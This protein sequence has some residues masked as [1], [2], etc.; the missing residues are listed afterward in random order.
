[1][2]KTIRTGVALAVA[3]ALILPLG[4]NA[5]ASEPTREVDP[6]VA[7]AA[8]A[9]KYM[10]APARINQTVP[11]RVPAPRGV[12]VTVLNPGIPAF[13]LQVNGMEAA[14]KE[15]GW[16]L[17]TVTYDPASPA[18]LNTAMLKAL[19]TDPDVTIN[20][21]APSTYSA[22]TV[23]EY[24]NAGVPIVGASICPFSYK[25]PIFQ[26]A[27]GCAN[28]DVAGRALANWFIA[29]SRGQGRA[30]FGSLTAI[31]TL[32]AFA[33]AFR[34]EVAK[35]CPKCSVE[36]QDTTLQAIGT[37]QFI[38]SLVNRLRQ[39]P[40]LKYLFFDNAS[41]ATGINAALDAAGL[42]Y[43]KV[44]GRA[45]D[46]AAVSALQQGK[47]A[48]WIAFPYYVAGY[49]NIDAALRLI[50]KSSGIRKNEVSPF[51]ILT[52]K[53]SGRVTLPY[54]APANALQQYMRIWRR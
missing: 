4:S 36:T 8:I 15:L 43:V 23:S 22:S 3:G 54:N 47:Q 6:V 35:K 42:G 1:M 10:R 16:T 53:N 28:E 52:P 34:D 44:G 33:T 46:A 14:A 30:L 29:D 27:N 40:S 7:A 17:T 20:P 31:P 48:A 18:S 26:G 11:L 32:V 45:A 21:A 49:G 25:P 12:R 5:G 38:P 13:V 19:Q 9:S 2:R 37:N 50:T 41:W 39:D 51:Q 24:A